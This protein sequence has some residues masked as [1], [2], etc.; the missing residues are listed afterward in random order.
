MSEWCKGVCV[1][2]W[3]K[4]VCVSEW[5]VDYVSV[6]GKAVFVNLSFLVWLCMHAAA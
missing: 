1:S 3:C 5:C 6:G 4:G 2:E